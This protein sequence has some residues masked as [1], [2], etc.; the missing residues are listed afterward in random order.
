LAPP[1]YSSLNATTGSTRVALIAGTL[2][3]VASLL[4]TGP[5]PLLRSELGQRLNLDAATVALT[6]A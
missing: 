5:G 2:G 6:I 4:T 3:A 1:V